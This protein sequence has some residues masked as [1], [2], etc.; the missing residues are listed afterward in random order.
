MHKVA[1]VADISRSGAVVDMH[2]VVGCGG[3]YA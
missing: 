2:K 3:G 1:G